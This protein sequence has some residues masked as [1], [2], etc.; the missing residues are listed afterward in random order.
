VNKLAKKIHKKKAAKPKVKGYRQEISIQKVSGKPAKVTLKE[1]V[2]GEAP[3]EKVFYLADGRKLK[4]LVELTE[5]LE[6]MHED[7][8]RHH[9]NDARNDFSNWINDVFKDRELA[10]EMKSIRDRSD[11]EIRLLKHFVKKLTSEA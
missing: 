8:F 3:R 9:V 11:A 1:H 10:Q 7:V 4:N 2:F 5:A 6:T